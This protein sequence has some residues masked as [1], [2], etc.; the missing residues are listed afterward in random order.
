MQFR[1]IPQEFFC[2]IGRPRKTRF[3]N[4]NLEHKAVSRLSCLPT[5]CT[6]ARAHTHTHTP[7][8]YFLAIFGQHST[9]PFL[10]YRSC[11]CFLCGGANFYEYFINVL[12]IFLG[13]SVMI[14]SISWTFCHC[15]T[16]FRGIPLNLMDLCCGS[17][18][19]LKPQNPEKLKIGQ[20]Y[21]TSRS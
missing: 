9:L 1:F 18:S 4:S 15:S 14:P 5:P 8:T 21:V 10:C 6:R 2:V 20:K 17:A 19:L 12:I 13:L 11:C 16:T 7:H 3:H